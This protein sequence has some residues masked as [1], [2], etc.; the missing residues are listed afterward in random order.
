MCFLKPYFAD[1]DD[2]DRNRSKRDPPSI[3]AQYDAEIAKI[4]DHRVLGTRK[5][6]TKTEFLVHLKGKSAADPVCDKAK[7]LWQFDAQTKEYLKTIL[8][9]TSSSSGTG[10][11]LDL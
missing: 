9:R 11:L 3:T 1:A 10:S 7:N 2:M 8:M 4:L 6:N 5:N